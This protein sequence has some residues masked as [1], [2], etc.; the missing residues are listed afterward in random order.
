MPPFV[1]PTKHSLDT[2][3]RSTN[4]PPTPNNRS[5]NTQK[6]KNK[7]KKTPQITEKGSVLSSHAAFRLF[8]PSASL[9]FLFFN[10]SFSS[11]IN[12]DNNSSDRALARPT[13]P[14]R[15]A[16]GPPSRGAGT[17]P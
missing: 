8:V 9:F 13:H 16:Y 12:R 5:Q 17:G 7:I 15:S 10:A 14:I 1:V 3:Y 6:N 11:R 2:N 4:A